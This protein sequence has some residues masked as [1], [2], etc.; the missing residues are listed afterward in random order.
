MERYKLNQRPE[1]IPIPTKNDFWGQLPRYLPYER[2]RKIGKVWTIIQKNDNDKISFFLENRFT[3]EQV[4]H[5]KSDAGIEG[6]NEI[7]EKFNY[8][9]TMPSEY[10]TQQQQPQPQPGPQPKQLSESEKK[11]NEQLE[12][13]RE[14]IE[15]SNTYMEERDKAFNYELMVQRFDE[16]KESFSDFEKKLQAAKPK[17]TL[18][19]IRE[20]EAGQTKRNNSDTQL[21]D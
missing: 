7:N 11:L 9:E 16:I 5:T 18:E 14:S 8:Y 12:L 20:R 6:W 2:E 17:I 1:L 19:Q 15:R 4:S 21:T 10:R 3:G 13:M